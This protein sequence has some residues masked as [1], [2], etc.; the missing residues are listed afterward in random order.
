MN[1]RTT[2][3]FGV[4]A[5]LGLATA[6]NADI[7]TSNEQI[8]TD[9]G[10]IETANGSFTDADGT[11]PGTELFV[12][13]QSITLDPDNHWYNL[14]DRVVVRNGATITIPAGT[15]FASDKGGADQG[16][17]LVI[18]TEGQIMAMGTKDE[19]IYFTS[20]DNMATW[21]DDGSDIT[22]KDRDD[23]Q[24]WRRGVD[25]WGSVA[26]LGEARITD[27]RQNPNNGD[28]LNADKTA[29]IEGLPNLQDNVNFYGGLDDNDDSGVMKYVSLSYGGDNFNPQ[30][31]AELNGMSWGGV[32]RGFDAHH[33]E[34]YNN[35]DDGLEIFGGTASVKN[36]AVWNIGDDSFD[37][38]QGWR[39]QAQF[40][41]LVQGAAASADQGSGYGDNGFE[42]DG[43]D[44]DTDA[45]PFSASQ[46]YN[47]TV[48]GAPDIGG[49]DSSD[50]L[51]ELRDNMNIQFVNSIFMTVGERVLVN[52]VTDGD[53]SEGFGGTNTSAGSNGTLGFA[54]RFV[55]PASY[56]RNPGDN[57]VPFPAQ[58]SA[59]TA[60]FQA[61]YQDQNPDWPLINIRGSVFWN[62]DNLGQADTQISG[63]NGVTGNS[64]SVTLVP[65]ASLDNNVAQASPIED[66]AR[67]T[68]PG[69][70]FTVASSDAGDGVIGNI[71]SLDPR[72]KGAATASLQFEAP[73]NGFYSAVDYRGAVGPD[74]NWLAGW[75][76]LSANRNPE[77]DLILDTADAKEMA[78]NTA[79]DVS[80]E[81]AP[82]ITF[83]SVDGVTY[84]V[85]EIDENGNEQV[86]GTVEGTGGEINVADQLGELDASAV[87]EVQIAEL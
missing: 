79:S 38:D 23:H 54:D 63:T 76:G 84:D 62:N 73:I 67:A 15:V 2:L 66:V 40:V 83:Q 1:M 32:G 33:I 44:G 29:P 81:I 71:T 25:E 31:D 70:D 34:I 46:I 75:T 27:T 5:G 78:G 87:Y 22:G 41:L 43:A 16:G 39:G 35:V 55:T 86:V 19:P 85:V 8:F 47:A 18:T 82:Q 58:G 42:M 13:D 11:T 36:L 24:A 26:I 49:Q 57:A 64:D 60:D 69:S 74:F 3:A 30:T 4:A 21:A 14:R 17:S 28:T 9:G 6:A 52:G 68:S 12:V 72:S 59:T 65:N 53:G 10:T 45:Q 37:V 77:G 51:I 50:N 61:A 48:I 20:K 7:D 56:Y 80:A